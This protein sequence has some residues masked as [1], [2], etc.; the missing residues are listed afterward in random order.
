MSFSNEV[1]ISTQ[2]VPSAQ[3]QEYWESH[4]DKYV[5]DI[6]CPPALST[7]IEAVLTHRDLNILKVNEI[8]ANAHSVHRSCLSIKNDQRDSIF[9]CL[10]TK[11]TG[12]SYQGTLSAQHSP[13]DMV[14][15]D[16]KVPYGHGFPDDMSMFVLDMPR[17]LF[18]Q[19]QLPNGQLLK[20]DKQLTS[21][22][23]STDA[24]LK[25]LTHKTTN[26]RQ[27]VIH[28]EEVVRHIQSL[29][30][31]ATGHKSNQ[32][33]RVLFKE[34]QEYIEANLADSELNAEHLSQH[35]SVTVRQLSRAFESHGVSINRYI[36][37]QR[38][39]KTREE[40]ICSPH[41]SITEIAFSWGFNHSA[42]F[43]RVYKQCFGE[44][45][46]QTQSRFH[47]HGA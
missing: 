31:V 27:Q 5:I 36:W 16:T 41:L 38:L 32:Y 46:R 8:T 12:Y 28:G 39:Q 25:L 34:C 9:A 47:T 26:H 3:R 37:R 2:H 33:L 43:S 21:G 18:E 24:I 7:E 23:S 10:M 35:F 1:I 20:I 42:H 29:L 22:A 11:G 4:V 15:Y 19:S 14:I 40:L 6:D 17:H 30:L 44:T 13:G 45:P